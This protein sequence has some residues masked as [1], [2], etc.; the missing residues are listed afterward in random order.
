MSDKDPQE[1]VVIRRRVVHDEEHH[2]GAWKIAFA[3]FMTAMMAL[4]LVLWLI[5][6]TSDKTKRAVAQYFNPVKLVD[7][8]TLKKG[9]QD[10]KETEMGAGPSIKETTT[11]RAQNRS[12]LWMKDVNSETAAKAPTHSEAALF[13]DPYAVLSEIA[14]DAHAEVPENKSEPARSSMGAPSDLAESYNDPF[15]TVPYLPEP[16]ADV[17]SPSAQDEAAKAKEGRKGQEL[18]AAAEPSASV[19]TRAAS[20][21]KLRRG[22]KGVSETPPA[23]AAQMNEGDSAKLR[24]EIFDA[25]R[26]DAQEQKLP[27][28]EVRAVEEGV[29]ISLTDDQNYMMFAIG[30]AEPLPKTIEVM[31]KIGR[32][33]KSRVGSVVV[34]GHTDGRSY[35]SATY[36][37][38]RLSA[39]RAHMAHYMLVRGG[40]DE[41]RFEKIEGYADRRLKFQN[42]PNAAGNR[43][44]EILL[45]K[46]KS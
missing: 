5:S 11:E 43:R 40:L 29:L 30:S 28:I 15:Q 44:I 9:F 32:L 36:D 3:D 20:M 35:K 24:A 41:R 31:E 22:A 23:N 42:D 6:T 33:L 17:T 18:R 45:R 7:M 12:P 38:W 8:T 37:N 16:K 14:A 25:V 21:A 13:R 4:F 19:A 46:E 2:G 39:A 34:R 27:H 10:P 26:T 1:I